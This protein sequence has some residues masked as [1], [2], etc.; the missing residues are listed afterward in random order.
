M[1]N[2][3]NSNDNFPPQTPPYYEQPQRYQGSSSCASASLI[4]GILSL[5]SICCMPPLAL[6]FAGLALILGALSKGDRTRPQNAR[7]GMILSGISLIAVLILLVILQSAFLLQ[8]FCDCTDRLLAQRRQQ[9]F[10]A[11]KKCS[12]DCTESGS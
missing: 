2:F 11:D 4:L 6:V 7:V 8:V 10:G 12:K 1:D 3:Y 5:L 9:Q